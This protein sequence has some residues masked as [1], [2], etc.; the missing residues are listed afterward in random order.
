MTSLGRSTLAGHRGWCLHQVCAFML[1]SAILQGQQD[2]RLADEGPKTRCS[3]GAGL[4]GMG[5]GGVTVRKSTLPFRREGQGAA[6]FT[7]F[8]SF[9]PPQDE[10]ETERK[11][12][13]REVNSQPI[14]LSETST[15][16]HELERWRSRHFTRIRVNAS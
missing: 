5:I 6:P 9:H 3:S 16:D 11:L 2:P 13:S 10:K 4:D 7:P 12:V 14:L 8:G 15:R 1:T